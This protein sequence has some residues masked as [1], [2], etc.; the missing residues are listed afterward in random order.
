MRLQSLSDL[1]EDYLAARRHLGFNVERHG[2]LLRNFAR[3]TDRIGYHG[4]ITVDLALHWVMAS[5]PGEPL[6]AERRLSAVRQFARHRDLCAPSR[7]QTG[8]FLMKG[9]AR[10]PTWRS[11]PC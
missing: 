6:R 8:S 3:F 7:V 2:W 1:V 4:P 5:C 10:S 11:S 9:C